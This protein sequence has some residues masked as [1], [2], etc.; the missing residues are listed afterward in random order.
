MAFGQTDSHQSFRFD[1]AP[2]PIV[3]MPS[4]KTAK[5]I[6]SRINADSESINRCK[7]LFI[8]AQDVAFRQI[9][10]QSRNKGRVFRKQ[11]P[12]SDV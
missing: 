9:N 7:V 10:N 11:W 5:N 8:R 2:P 12:F 1:L 4:S 6:W 3:C